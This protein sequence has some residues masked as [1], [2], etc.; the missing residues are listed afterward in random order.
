MRDNPLGGTEF[1]NFAVQKRLP[2]NKT[3]GGPLLARDDERHR[4]AAAPSTGRL[5][6][7]CGVDLFLQP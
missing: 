5:A 1:Q 4:S 2:K 3:A 7:A 6:A